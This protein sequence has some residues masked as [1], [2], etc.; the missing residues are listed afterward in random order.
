MPDRLSLEFDMS[1][2]Y[3]Y[4]PKK[5]RRKKKHLYCVRKFNEKGAENIC[6]QLGYTGGTK[7]PARGGTGPI[8]AGNRLCSGGEKTVFDCPLQAERTD[9][10]DCNHDHDMGVHCTREGGK[11]LIMNILLQVPGVY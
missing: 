4:L 11:E 1:K 8:N 2:N 9:A 6:I 7:Y 3:P 5:I 10:T